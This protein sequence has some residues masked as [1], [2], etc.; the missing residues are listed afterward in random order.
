M[1]REGAFHNLAPG[2]ARGTRAGV[3]CGREGGRHNVSWTFHPKFSNSGARTATF[4]RRT[5]SSVRCALAY[6][7]RICKVTMARANARSTSAHAPSAGTAATTAIAPL[8]SVS[9]PL[10]TVSS[11]AALPPSSVS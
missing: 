2:S 1:T 11:V 5:L 7:R 4:S 8:T 9:R 6:E 10:A 3:W